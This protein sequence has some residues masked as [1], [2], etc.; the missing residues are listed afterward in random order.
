MRR[1]KIFVDSDVVLS[2]LLSSSGAAHFILNKAILDLDLFISNISHQ[3]LK[4][5]IDKL[6]LDH[7]Q[8]QSLLKNKFQKIKLKAGKENLDKIKITL[9]G[10][11]SDENDAHIVAGAVNAKTKLIL[12][13]NLRHFNVEKLKRD[14]NIIVST[15]AQF[16]EYLR[17]LQ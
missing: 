8:L 16:L 4:R 9:G 5:G 3:E 17:S 11:V 13:Y 12:S 14:F 7:E 10:Y 6:H 1:R 15:P 2:S